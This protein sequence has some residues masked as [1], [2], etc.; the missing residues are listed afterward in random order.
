MFDAHAT[1]EEDK[2]VLLCALGRLGA[3]TQE[4]LLRFA[5]ETGLQS[6]FQF[7]LA[8]AEL[9]EAGLVREVRRLEGAL[10]VLSPEGRQSMELF[11]ARIR[12]S[13]EGKLEQY[14]A[15]WKE[16][17]REELQMPASYEKSGDGYAVTLRALESGAEIF[18][19]TLTAA[20]KEQAK[21]F[22]ERW[23]ERAPDLY[24]AI[25]EQLGEERT[26]TQEEL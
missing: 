10:L 14:A 20:T 25:M 11:G 23:P 4:Q 2:L 15:E 16:R 21:R 17:I 24:R 7:L 22:C 1:Q 9:R 18:S 3:C 12:A 5:V 19:M 8:L 26:G 13:L 6:Q